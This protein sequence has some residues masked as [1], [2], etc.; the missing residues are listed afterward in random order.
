MAFGVSRKASGGGAGTIK[1]TIFA[2]FSN[3][4]TSAISLLHSSPVPSH[5]YIL[6][7]LRRS[8][9]NPP[10]DIQNG[11]RPGATMAECAPAY[12]T[13]MLRF[14]FKRHQRSM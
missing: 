8:S 9:I 5:P 10:K 11:L 4:N 1:I 13:T 3:A 12:L 14:F 7:S 6:H 2:S